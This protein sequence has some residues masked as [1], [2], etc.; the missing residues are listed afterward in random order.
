MALLL[1]LRD[2]ETMTDLFVYELKS[3][4]SNMSIT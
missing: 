3:C 2:T 4:L 1:E